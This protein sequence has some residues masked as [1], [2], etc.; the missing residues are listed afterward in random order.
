MDQHILIDGPV[1]SSRK[2]FDPNQTMGALLATRSCE[3]L[4]IVVP[5]MRTCKYQWIG[6]LVHPLSGGFQRWCLAPQWFTR[7]ILALE[8]FVDLMFGG[9][10]FWIDTEA[11]EIGGR[12]IESR[13]WRY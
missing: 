13:S 11:C 6:S 5:R 2:L 3:K 7:P 12:G 10:S 9:W 8:S 4:P 1:D